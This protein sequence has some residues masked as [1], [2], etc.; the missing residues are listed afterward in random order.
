MEKSLKSP[1][2]GAICFVLLF[3]GYLVWSY[4]FQVKELPSTPKDYKFFHILITEDPWEKKGKSSALILKSDIQDD[5]SPYKQTFF[6]QDRFYDP[7]S[8][9]ATTI[10]KHVHKNDTLTIG[11]LLSE[12]S[13]IQSYGSN[14]IKDD[15]FN[16][17]LKIY[18]IK[19]NDQIIINPEFFQG[20]NSI[21]KTVFPILFLLLSIWGIGKIIYLISQ[22]VKFFT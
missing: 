22:K 2:F 5:L 10:K 12:F 4:L 17:E 13:K 20:E 6:L 8:Y 21:A 18:W 19:K 11:V 1:Y 7:E 16:R 9:T 15:F 14:F 3:P